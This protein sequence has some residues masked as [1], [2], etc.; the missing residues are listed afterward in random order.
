MSDRI[1]AI[2]ER[3]EEYPPSHATYW[4]PPGY[5]AAARVAA[6]D[7][8]WLLADAERLAAALEADASGCAF[9]DDDEALACWVHD[10]EWPSLDDGCEWAI[11]RSDA[12]KAHREQAP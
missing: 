7:R 9:D 5:G 12:L 1:T 2:R 8:E 6:E 3:A 11:E 4:Q 10:A